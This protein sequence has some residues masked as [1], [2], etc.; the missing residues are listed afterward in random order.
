MCKYNMYLKLRQICFYFILI[1]TDTL[2]YFRKTWFIEAAAKNVYHCP[3]RSNPCRRARP[4]PPP[5]PWQSWHPRSYSRPRLTILWAKT[6]FIPKVKYF[7]TPKKTQRKPFRKK[8]TW[9]FF[10]IKTFFESFVFLWKIFIFTGKKLF[11]GGYK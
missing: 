2:P 3:S 11:S 5:R 7:Y 10:F 9:L 8:I 6:F 1:L 4:P